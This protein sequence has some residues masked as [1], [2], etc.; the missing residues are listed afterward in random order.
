M[1]K[2]FEETTAGRRAKK[3]PALKKAAVPKK[4]AG[5]PPAGLVRYAALLRGVSPMNCKMPA[6]KAAF[7]KHGFV[8]VKTVISSGNVV[9]TAPAASDAEIEAQCE[10]AMTQ[11]MDRSFLTIVRRVDALRALIASEPFARPDVTAQHKRVVTFVREPRAKLDLPRTHRGATILEERDG[12]I[13]TAYLSA[14]ND[15]AFMTLLERAYGKAITTRTL[16]T[17]AKL[18]T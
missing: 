12:A 11:Y 3:A 9:F 14:P 13:F 18:A 6:L 2:R 4:I 5:P 8:D 10:A 17:V 16:E 7:V 15:A 1:K